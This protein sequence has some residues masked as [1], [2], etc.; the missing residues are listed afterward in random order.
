MSMAI[1]S[2][3]YVVEGKND[4]ENLPLSLYESHAISSPRETVSISLN[5]F[6][7]WDV[8]YGVETD[9]ENVGVDRP[10]WNRTTYEKF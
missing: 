5:C 10:P 4:G 2:A 7:L 8:F 3:A 1:C 6:S 9:L